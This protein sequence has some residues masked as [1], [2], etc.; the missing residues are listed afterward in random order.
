MCKLKQSVT[1][2]HTVYTGSV[3]YVDT[4]PVTIGLQQYSASEISKRSL[5]AKN[6]VASKTV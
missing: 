1:E 3:T 6:I 4:Q 5:L 2:V